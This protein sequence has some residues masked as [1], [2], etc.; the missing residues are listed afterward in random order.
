MGF[1][2]AD[3]IM[4]HIMIQTQTE[5]AKIEAVIEADAAHP[6]T[7]DQPLVIQ[8]MKGDKHLHVRWASHY[9][10]N[11][12]M[13]IIIWTLISLLNDVRSRTPHYVIS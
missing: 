2:V 3:V 13:L 9:H 6:S 12:L 10:L 1:M 8:E 5:E 7:M 4:I 11:V